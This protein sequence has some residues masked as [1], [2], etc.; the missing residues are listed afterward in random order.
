MLSSGGV[1]ER[2]R[3][4]SYRPHNILP[5]TPPIRQGCRN[6]LN[7]T[8]GDPIVNE[9]GARPQKLRPVRVV[10]LRIALLVDA[11]AAEGGELGEDEVEGLGDGEGGGEG[12]FVRGGHGWGS[13]RGENFGAGIKRLGKKGRSFSPCKMCV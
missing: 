2:G 10:H 9:V 5:L 4:V 12:I 1:R 3:V 13:W 11:V 7:I 6:L 8:C